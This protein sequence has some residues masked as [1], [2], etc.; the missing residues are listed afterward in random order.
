MT[1]QDLRRTYRK[2]QQAL[3]KLEDEFIAT[4]LAAAP[5]LAINTSETIATSAYIVLAHA[6]LEGFFEDLAFWVLDRVVTNWTNHRRVSVATACLLLSAAPSAVDNTKTIFNQIREALDAQKAAMSRL[7]R[8]DNHGISERHLRALLG[9]LGVGLEVATNPTQVASLGNLARERG[10][11][12]HNNFGATVHITAS[13]AKMW[14]DDCVALAGD[15]VN[16][17]IAMGT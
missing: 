2:L 9:P 6:A 10:S 15:M 14:V 17:A 1:G 4:Y 16:H 8:F 12:A 11:R 13:S 3:R 7:I 5:T